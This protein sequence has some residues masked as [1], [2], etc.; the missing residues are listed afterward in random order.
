LQVSNEIGLKY[1]LN[2]KLVDEKDII[3]AN[4]LIIH[5]MDLPNDTTLKR[6]VGFI[7]RNKVNWK[8]GIFN[9]TFIPPAILE[10]GYPPKNTIKKIEV[11]G[12]PI[13]C[14]V[15]RKNIDDLLGM[16]A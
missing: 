15:E 9:P 2:K 10:K 3:A 1:L 16:G 11:G 13:C 5:D 7:Q 8:Y 14:I 4:T 6:T 12:V